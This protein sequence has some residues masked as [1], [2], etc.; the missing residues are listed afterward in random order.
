M[1]SRISDDVPHILGR[2]AEFAASNTGAEAVI[3][4]ADRLVLE[5]VREIVFALG[6]RTDKDAYAFSGTKGLDVIFDSNDFSIEA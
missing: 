3:A 2:M 1:Y 4:D 6:H 5:G